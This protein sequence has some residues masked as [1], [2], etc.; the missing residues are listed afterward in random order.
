MP[1]SKPWYQ[2]RT[3]LTN[4]ALILVAVL[5]YLAVEPT[6]KDIAVYFVIAVNVINIVLRFITV[7]PLTVGPEE[8]QQ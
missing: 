7:Q 2:S 4:I 1:E 5:S 6:F 3:V 8:R